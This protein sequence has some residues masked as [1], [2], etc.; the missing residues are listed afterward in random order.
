[1][2]R[3]FALCREGLVSRARGGLAGELM[4][5]SRRSLGHTWKARAIGCFLRR[6]RAAKPRLRAR[7]SARIQTSW[8]RVQRSCSPWL[9][10]SLGDVT[11]ARFPSSP[12]RFVARFYA[13]TLPFLSSRSPFGFDSLRGIVARC[14]AR[15]GCFAFVRGYIG[16]RSNRKWRISF[17]TTTVGARS[18]VYVCRP[19]GEDAFVIQSRAKRY[20]IDDQR[21]Y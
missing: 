11:L 19:L 2:S 4:T 5:R 21:G 6:P 17:D 1:M 16:N 7:S 9:M 8:R 18:E 20:L 10:C 12:A 14:C 13:P 3:V 15:R